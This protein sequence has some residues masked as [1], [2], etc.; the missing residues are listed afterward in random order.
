MTVN[1]R[2]EPDLRHWLVEYFVTTIGGSGDEIDLDATLNEL[3]MG[4]RDAVV[5]AGELSEL[6]GR[7]VSPL[8]FWEQPTINAL[9]SH[10]M[11]PEQQAEP[12]TVDHGGSPNDPIA[13]IGLG[14]RFPGGITGP[15]ALWQFLCEGRSSIGEVP[16]DRWPQ[17]DDGSPEMAA[18]LARTTRWGSFLAEIDAFDAE[19]FD[20][21]PSEAAKMDP[22]QRLL[23]EVAYEALERAGIPPKSLR[24][25]QTGVF[26]GACLSEYGY[27]A[28]KDLSQV[29]A[30]T[31]TG[32]ALS[33]VA[34]RLSYFLDLRGPSVAVDTA[35]SSSLVAVHLACQSLRTGD[36]RL[37]VAGGVNL[38]L[39]PAVTRSFDTAEVMS[40]TGGCHAFDAGADGFV[41]GEGCGVVVL[42]RLADAVRDGDP[43]LAVVRGSAVNQDGHSNGLMA[44]NPGAQI[45]VLRAACARAGI[46]PRDID[47]VETHGT[48]TLLGDPIEARALGTVF[49]RGRADGAPLLLGAVK[50]N[51]GHL[52]AAAG[53]A[54]FIKA[55]L[56]VQRGHI[57]PN[58]DFKVPNPLIQFEDMRLKVV[59]EPTDWP[60]TGRPRRAGVSSFGFGGT[61]AHVVVE[62]GGCAE[63]VGRGPEPVVSTVVVSGKSV[64]RVRSWAGVLADWMG[65]DGVSVGLAD[66]AHAVNHHRG[67]LGCFASVCARDRAGAVAGLRAV[68]AGQPAPGVVGVHAG[69]CAPGTVFVFSGQ[70]SQ[71]AGMG[72]RLLAEEPAFAAAVAGLEPD[73]VAQTGFSLQQTLTCGDEVAG[74][75][76]IQ[77]VLVGVQLALAALWRSYGVTPDAVIGHSMGE[78]SAAV[79]AGALSMADG[80]KVI[81]TR[82]RLL[83][84]LSGQGAMALVELH[85]Q[86]TAELI[87][88]YPQLSVA[89][90]ASPRQTVIAGPA[91]QIDAVIA[92][93]ESQ[94]RL[95]R[96]IEVDVASHHRMV[97]PVLGPLRAA[98]ADV[99]PRAGS[100]PLISTT[101]E[102]PGEIAPV[103]DADYW[104]ANL[105][106]PVRFAQ[107]ITAAGAHH[108]RF[109]E[110]SPH[111]LLTYAISE[112][113]TGVHHHAI[114]TLARDTDDTT[115]FHTN[116]N[117]AH[118]TTPPPTPHPPEPHPAIPT[119][120]WHHTHHWI[121]PPNTPRAAGTHPLLGTGVTDPTSGTRIWENN[122]GPNDLWLG[123]HSVDDVC[124]LPGAAYAE[125]ALAAMT[126]AF[127]AEGHTWTIRE[128]TLDRLMHLAA[129]TTIVTTLAGDE[130]MA[131]IEIGTR[132]TTSC[133]TKHASATVGLA[134]PRDDVELP[135]PLDDPDAVAV[136][137]AHLYRRLRSAGQQHGPA[138]QGITSLSVS[139]SGVA[140]ADVA[141]PS[142][143]KLGCRQLLLHPIMVD[144]ALQT[145]G[146]TKLAADLSAQASEPMCMLPTRLAGIEVHGDVSQAVRAVGSLRTTSMSDHF[147]GRAFLIGP[148]GRVLLEINEIEMVLLR[149]PVRGAGVAGRMFALEWEPLSLET[150]ANVSVDRVLLVAECTESDPQPAALH[151]LLSTRTA[152][153]E[154]VRS[155]DKDALRAAITRTDIPWDAIVVVCPPRTVDEALTEDAQF[156]LV[157]ERTL[158]IAGIASEIAHVGARDSPRLWIVT[159]GA[160]RFDPS[161]SVTLAQSQLR[162]IARVL[163]FEHPELRTTILDVEPDG[164][165]SPIA[166]VEELLADTDQDEVAIRQGKR[167]VRRL[168]PVPTTA[169]GRPAVEERYT[170]VNLD[171][172]GAVVLHGAEGKLKTSAATRVSPQADEVEVRVAAAAL[173]GT[174][175]VK[176]GACVGVVTA[177]GRH[178]S[179]IEVGQ[180]VIA[181]GSS[182]PASHLTAHQDA[183]VPI[184]DAVCDSDGIAYGSGYLT[185]WT[186]LRDVARLK[187][188][189]RVL[190]HDTT[191]GVGLAARAIAEMIGARVYVAD[192]RDPTIADTVCGMTDGAGMNVV[193]NSDSGEAIRTGVQLLAPGGRFVQVA[194]GSLT[195]DASLGVAA[196]ARSGSF[197][198]IDIDVNLEHDVRRCRQLVEQVLAA[199]A[200]GALRP[201]AITEFPLAK[202]TDTSALRASEGPA[203]EIVIN[204]PAGGLVEAVAPRP[205]PAVTRD[206]GYIVVGGM[207]GVGFAVARW[208]A[209]QGAGMVVVNGRS[210]PEAEISAAITDLNAAGGNVK[211]LTG[212]ICDPRTARRLVDT[213]ENAGFRVRGVVHSATVV[214]DQIVLNM[215]PDRLAR[216]LAPKVIGGWRL[217]EATAD[218]ELDWWV[219][220]S[221][222]ASLLGSPG[223]G[224]YAAANSWLDGL[225]AYRRSRGLPA[226]G[227][228]WGP[229]AEVGRAQSFADLGFSMMTVEQGLTALRLLLEADRSS[230]GVFSLD[231]RQWFQSFPAAAAS[232]L[233]TRLRDVAEAPDDNDGRIRLE[234]D[235]LDA[236]ERSA[237]LA[238][239]IAEEIKAV[240][241]S[242]EPTDHDQAL[243]SLGLDSLMG[244]ELRNRLESRLG[245]TLPVALVWAY[246]TISELA[247]AMC[248]RLGYSES[249]AEPGLS[250]AEMALLSEV[251][252][253]SELQ[254]AMGPEL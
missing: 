206:G 16:P 84:G 134:A 240:L 172:T 12:D 207:G 241:R 100:I 93:V 146:A 235:A 248:T 239:L 179:R 95:A 236:G 153:C 4:S 36:S 234:L 188:G 211:Q 175:P 6:L 193:M 118:T 81:A 63:Q 202:L 30:W 80:L 68:A 35:C 142:F 147:A 126:D 185:A 24:R 48:G 33:I 238:S 51:V 83:S 189:E 124:A 115:S 130:S 19:F 195:A 102:H 76:R 244:L 103:C 133:W 242:A 165:L 191:D 65:G 2:D 155:R 213:V 171:G 164:T 169:G 138:F 192:L 50:S 15:E 127:G 157:Q 97:D 221:S 129:E 59:A 89:V 38:L 116:L 174:E 150:P 167:Y 10:L 37:A 14:C 228:N 136:D 61:N 111:P 34:N 131:H 144:V 135:F 184:T 117:A 99:S 162:G 43:V 49:G 9:S 67:S 160:Q 216:V 215:S 107:A 17:F 199:A 121:T 224:A 41:R 180:R 82:S 8:D 28:A 252:A 132:G 21:S 247:D 94:G 56:A 222:A 91:P 250:K 156:D 87:A 106:N 187:S 139:D 77:P 190:I 151:A 58:L 125:I 219:A 212:D 182:A 1:I 57:P 209:E 5:L 176:A 31:G 170:V 98:L 148:D 200:V 7:S 120:P 96:R 203:G 101:V 226:V 140:R 110:V 55:T 196:L 114:A 249:A 223:Q 32:G 53:I 85:A 227:I 178:V 158:L 60:I 254:A 90:Y 246:P 233:F 29:D 128:L 73:F 177:V 229:W 47:Y 86:A 88:G 225:I 218:R 122:I 52:E 45:A 18:A 108:A 71:W 210:A 69:R 204:M 113:L 159:S 197:S 198:V 11:A 186:A 161:D 62:Q 220:F 13:V 208:L 46:D 154:L 230:T 145:L 44:P 23:L 92:M 251:V 39:S 112:N 143:A 27:L 217:H 166:V 137:P 105:R 152:G 163:T 25:S 205:G 194:N 109:I 78:V 231:A 181:L 3:G 40:P 66:V 26:V 245:I 72:R 214:A 119:T 70:G 201:P 123:H 42:K 54:G 253:A 104:A 74:I 64:D 237:R 243:A 232:S 183:V 141:L 173:I 168:L 20:I 22:Q 75:E 149:V 79:V